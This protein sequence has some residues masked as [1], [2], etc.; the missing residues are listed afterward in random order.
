MRMSDFFDKMNHLLFGRS[1]DN[2]LLKELQ[3]SEG[4][5]WEDGSIC[6]NRIADKAVETTRRF[7]STKELKDE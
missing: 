6:T 4:R 5:K 2:F 7:K 1:F 3:N